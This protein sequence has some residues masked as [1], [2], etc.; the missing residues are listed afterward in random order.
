MINS[1][2]GMIMPS[3]KFNT[4]DEWLAYAS[5]LTRGV[6]EYKLKIDK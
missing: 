2:P 5:K 1:N 4:D 3:Q 6:I